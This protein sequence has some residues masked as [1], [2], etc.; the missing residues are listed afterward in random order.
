VSAQTVKVIFRASRRKEPEVSAVIVG[1]PGSHTAPLS[2]W[3]SMCGHGSAS[4]QWYYSTR[5][6]KPAEYA[7]ELK[8]LRRQYAPEYRIRM[9]KRYTAKDCDELNAALRK[10][11]GI[12]VG[13]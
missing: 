3:D 13:K 12:E 2:V 6:A 11:T 8:Q 1:S 7:E 5:P 9:V 10:A 4:W